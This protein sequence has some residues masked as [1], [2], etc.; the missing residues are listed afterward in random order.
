MNTTRLG[1]T[2]ADGGKPQLPAYVETDPSGRYGRVSLISSYYY[3]IKS[4]NKVTF[5]AC[6]LHHYMQGKLP[7]FG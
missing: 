1:S 6:K 4:V 3:Y 7:N 2:C 5:V